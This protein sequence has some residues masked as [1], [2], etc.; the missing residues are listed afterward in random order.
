MKR[1]VFI[2]SIQI[3]VPFPKFLEILPVL[4]GFEGL[5][6][7]SYRV[8][9]SFSECREQGKKAPWRRLP[10]GYHGVPV[11][12]GAAPVSPLL[13]PKKNKRRRTS[14]E[15][16]GRQRERERER[17][18]ERTRKKNCR[19]R[20]HWWRQL[21]ADPKT[22]RHVPETRVGLDNFSLFPPFF[23]PQTGTVEPHWSSRK[24][25]KS[26]WRCLPFFWLATSLAR[27]W[28]LCWPSVTVFFSTK[29]S[30]SAPRSDGSVNGGVDFLRTIERRKSYKKEERKS[31]TL[32]GEAVDYRWNKNGT[33]WKNLNRIAIIF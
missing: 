1:L 24:T 20:S 29:F 18:R 10:E 19:P 31:S 7:W 6:T 12:H 14:K 13:N 22:S 28:T 11:G 30:S 9:T 2:L 15:G 5:W 33:R 21:R 25:D 17:E 3:F 4:M 26:R 23:L 27:R 16:G 8:F 32:V